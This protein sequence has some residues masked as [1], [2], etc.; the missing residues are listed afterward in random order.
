[1]TYATMKARATALLDALVAGAPVESAYHDNAVWRGVHPFNE[2]TGHAQ[3]ADVWNTLR[4]AIPDMERRTQMVLGG[5]NLPDTRVTTDRAADLVACSGV[6]Q[7]TMRGDLL[8]IP[9]TNGTVSVRFCE[10]HEL[11]DEKIV[12]SWVMFDLLDLMR[13]AQCWPLPQSLGAEAQWQ[14]PATGDGVRLTTSTTDSRAMDTVLKMHGALGNFDGKSLD[15]MNHGH[16]W[17]D[18]FMWYGPAGIG[19]TRG[20][21]GFR[22]HHQIP[23][24]RAYNDREGAGHYIRI[25]D[26]P[27]AVT[28]GWPSV[29]GTH[30]GEWLGMAPTGR[31]IEMRVMDFYRLDGDKI[32]ENWVPMDVIHIA[33]Q[34]GVDLFARVRH[35]TGQPDLTL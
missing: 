25:S 19:S 21:E 14:H 22:A 7:G 6:L 2:R 17:T 16:Y 15:S 26:G 18:T 20:L 10:A 29:R 23:F 35:M 24:L 1:M 31:M 12:Q 32:A 5:P 33:L 11:R 3:I 28:G 34:M 27:Y 13:Q 9:A 8:G 4:S 30:T